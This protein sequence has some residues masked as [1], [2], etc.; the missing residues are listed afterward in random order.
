MFATSLLSRFMQNPSEVHFIAVKRI[1]KYVKGTVNFGLIYMKQKSSQLLGFSDS[2]WAGFL[3]D[4]KSTR[5]FCFSFGSVVFGW[6]SKKQEVVTQSTAE[7]EY[8]ACAAAANH[9]LWLRKLLDELG[10]K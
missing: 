10:F 7:A 9:A 2:D 6:S 5:D 1:L 4:S 3:D 8:I